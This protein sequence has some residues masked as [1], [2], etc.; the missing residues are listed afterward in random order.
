M[1]DPQPDRDVSRRSFLHAAGAALALAGDGRG[2]AGKAA[3]PQKVLGRT[4]VKVPV[5]G[6]GTAPAGHRR[7]K[8]AVAF[9]HRCIDSG[10][11]Y[12]D[13]APGFTGYGNAQAYLGHVLRDRRREVFLVTKCFEPDGDKALEAARLPD[14]LRQA[15]LRY[16]LGLPQ[17]S[18]VVLGIRNDAELAQDL[19]WLRA[20]QPLG[21]EELKGLT[22]RTR[23]LAGRWG[24]VYGAVT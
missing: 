13:T 24:Q 9:Y 15:G 4:G 2:A 12:L 22:E 11:T 7:E 10:L 6:L 18:V 5:L 21:P 8:E 3:L 1:N 19:A 16:A 23:G 14:E 20:Y 17:V